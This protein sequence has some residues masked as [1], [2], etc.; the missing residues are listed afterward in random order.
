MV[1]WMRLVEA[2]RTAGYYML[3]EPLSDVRRLSYIE[4]R[5]DKVYRPPVSVFN[6]DPASARSFKRDVSVTSHEIGSRPNPPEGVN[7]GALW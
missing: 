1:L 2:I 7:A 3:I 4:A 6:V 5:I